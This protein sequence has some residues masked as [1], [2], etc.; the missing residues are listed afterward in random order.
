MSKPVT[1][2]H[3]LGFGKKSRAENGQDDDEA[4][5][6]QWAKLAE[7]DPDR[8]QKDGE[9]EDDYEARMK[10]MDEEDEKDE[11]A[12]SDLDGAPTEDPDDDG[13][14]DAGAKKAAKAARASERAR[15]ASIVAAGI[16]SNQLHTACSLAFDTSMSASEVTKVLSMSRHDKSGSSLSNRMAGV[17][18]PNPGTVSGK[19]GGDPLT[20]KLVSIAKAHTHR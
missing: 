11:Q 1:F 13:D 12:E 19:S 6:A 10:A 16:K 18:I 8:E 14:Q 5:R 4:K 15:C 7:E 2:A 9:S 3:L 20:D 17:D